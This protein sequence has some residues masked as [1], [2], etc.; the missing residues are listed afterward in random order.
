MAATFSGMH[1]GGLA[2]VGKA[3]CLP[4]LKILS[5]GVG[6][7]ARLGN[8]SPASF[9]LLAP[10][11]DTPTESLLGKGDEHCEEGVVSV[12][13]RKPA[14]CFKQSQKLIKTLFRSFV[15]E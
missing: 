15:S 1:N 12:P 7:G 2:V 3:P 9:T 5:A 10:F 8:V 14:E 13:L 11:T 6:E 4:S